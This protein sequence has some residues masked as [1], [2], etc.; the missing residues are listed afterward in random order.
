MAE[1]LESV[2]AMGIAQPGIIDTAK[3]QPT[4]QKMHQRMVDAG[5]A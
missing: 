1:G 2:V 5:T 4:M 3:R